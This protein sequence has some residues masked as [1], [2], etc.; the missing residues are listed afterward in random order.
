MIFKTGA[1]APTTNNAYE[2]KYDGERIVFVNPAENYEEI[3]R[4]LSTMDLAKARDANARDFL[5]C[6]L[7]FIQIYS[8]MIN[9][10]MDYAFCV[11]N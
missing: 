8:L 6:Y 5:M 11:E 1:G 4:I 3:R 9:H 2:L 10:F 7:K